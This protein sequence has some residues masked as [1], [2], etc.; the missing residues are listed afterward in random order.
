MPLHAQRVRNK[1][2]NAEIVQQLMTKLILG[3]CAALL[4]CAV[5]PWMLPDPKNAIK[6]SVTIDY[7][8]PSLQEAIQFDQSDYQ[9]AFSRPLFW[10][11]RLP[12]VV[13][14]ADEEKNSVEEAIGEEPDIRFLGIM[15]AGE[16]RQVWLAS[17][18][19][20]VAL[21]EGEEIA[22]WTVNELTEHTVILRN[23]AQEI[24]LPSKTGP[25]EK[26]ELRQVGE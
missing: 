21:S 17:A 9:E 20:V 23:G 22:G 24:V 16:V 18:A 25:S 5:L 10:K 8:I 2:M 11:E 13:E 1:I 14:S 3:G 12:P 7:S 6:K 19:E 4:L 26:I 15:L